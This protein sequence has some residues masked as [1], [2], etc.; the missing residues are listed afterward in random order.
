MNDINMFR[1]ELLPIPL[2][3]IADATREAPEW[4]IDWMISSSADT[5][6]DWSMSF[7]PY[8]EIQARVLE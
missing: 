3:P 8:S 4:R 6:V 1:T 7:L 5:S 2:G